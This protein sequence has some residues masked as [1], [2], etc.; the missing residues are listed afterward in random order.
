MRTGV[1]RADAAEAVARAKAEIA[2]RGLSATVTKAYYA[3]IVAQRKY[4]TAQ[5]ALD[6]AQ[7]SLHIS[8]DL[9]R[10]REVAHS[11][12]VKSQ[13]QDTPAAGPPG[14]PTRDGE[15][16]AGSGRAAV[17]RFQRKLLGRG[18]PGRGARSASVADVESYGRARESRCWRGHGHAARQPTRYHN[19][20]PGLSADAHGRRCLR[21]RSQRLR[22]PQHGR[23]EQRSR[24]AAEPRLLCHRQLEHS[25][26]GLGC[27]AQQ[28]TPGR[29]EARRGQPWI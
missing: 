21:H 26:L 12:V 2:R 9:E 22:S 14:S 1:Q 28:G 15:R 8:Q 17:P 6:Q 7:R 29:T 27:P 16:A 4:A 18:R 19:R 25:G 23:R 20:A 5:Q 13:L 11:D 3:L 10:G 24:P